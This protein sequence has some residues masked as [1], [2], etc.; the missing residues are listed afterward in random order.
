MKTVILISILLLTLSCK[1]QK[2]RSLLINKTFM[3]NIGSICE[4]TPDGYDCAC[5]EI[6]LILNFT[7]EDISIIEKEI[8]S[9]G[10]E[11]ITSKLIYK[12]ELTQNFETKIVSN[13]NEIAHGFLKDLVL[14][15]ENEKII[16][17]KKRRN[18]TTDKIEF[19]KILGKKKNN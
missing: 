5:I 7:K 13:P 18:K 12:W 3:A 2:N 4:E 11:N 15:V 19:E 8:S 1:A 14:K 6:Y 9:C 17:N 16:G 10:T